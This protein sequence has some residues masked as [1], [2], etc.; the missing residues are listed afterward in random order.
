MGGQLK[1][2]T[3]NLSG[4]VEMNTKHKRDIIKIK[5]EMANSDLVPDT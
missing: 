3:D 1:A 5:Q 4:E 2:L